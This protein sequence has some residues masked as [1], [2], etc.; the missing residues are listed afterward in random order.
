MIC[1]RATFQMR[2]RSEANV[3]SCGSEQLRIITFKMSTF[4]VPFFSL[5]VNV[6]N[7]CVLIHLL[8]TILPKV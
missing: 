3:V 6:Q 1:K 5:F 4:I 8:L 2:V 7:V